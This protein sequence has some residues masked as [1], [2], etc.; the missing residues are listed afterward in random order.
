[1]ESNKVS[2]VIIIVVVLVLVALA[3]LLFGSMM[4]KDEQTPGEKPSSS[5]GEKAVKP[6]LDLALNTS[7]ESQEK[8]VISATASMEDGSLITAIFLPDGTE[9]PA[10]EATYEVTENG[11]YTF[12]ALAENGEETQVSISVSNI[13]KASHLNPYIPEGFSH[14]E[15]TD[16]ENGFVIEDRYGNEF[17]WVPVE[18]G[19][20]ARDTLL[21]SKYEESTNTATALVNSV[22]QN[23]GFYIGRYEASEYTIN[24]EKT[25]ASMSGKIPWT[26][27]TYLDA[28][29]VANA[30]ASKYGYED[31]NT[32]MLNSYVWD[33][34][35]KWFDKRVE[36]YSSNTNYGNY[37]GAIYPAG[38]TASDIIYNICDIAGNVREWTTEIYKE[39]NFDK[40]EDSTI[41]YRVIRG[42]GASLSRTPKSHHGYPENTAEPY[43]GFRLILYK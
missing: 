1:M 18:T 38:G 25:A 41:K 35:L 23:Y 7:E 24:G 14:V 28:A 30:A 9:I 36:N 5:S 32:A 31:V 16:V 8:V 2:P 3:M 37:S 15:G 22:A 21:D 11:D 29:N 20:L 26:N 39:V 27:I 13:K 19:Q 4:S 17:V 10:A 43:W 34:I 33:T 40:D 6:T 42:G 12:K